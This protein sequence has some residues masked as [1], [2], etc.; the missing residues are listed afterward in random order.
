MPLTFLFSGDFNRDG[1]ADVAA[2]D[3]N[4]NLQTYLGTH[5]AGF[6]APVQSASG[7]NNEGYAGI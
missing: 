4:G 2:I 7:L 5:D 3:N 6:Q 1:V